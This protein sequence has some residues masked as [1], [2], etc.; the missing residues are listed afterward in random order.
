M[1]TKTKLAKSV[2]EAKLCLGSVL[3]GHS[4]FAFNSSPIEVGL[5][6]PMSSGPEYPPSF[7]DFIG[8]DG[9][10][11]CTHRNGSSKEKHDSENALKERNE[12]SKCF[13]ESLG[14]VDKVPQTP[15]FDSSPYCQKDDYDIEMPLEEDLVEARITWEVG[16]M[17]GCEV[18]N[19]KAMKCCI[20]QSQ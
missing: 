4:S 11:N 6:E 13:G 16:K 14:L 19:D 7:E 9:P 5:E 2:E 3:E 10:L 18:N 1:G 12:A 17:L 8:I 20:G 15:L